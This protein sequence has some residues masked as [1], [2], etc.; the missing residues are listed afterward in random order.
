MQSPVQTPNSIIIITNSTQFRRLSRWIVPR[1]CFYARHYSRSSWHDLWHAHEQP[2]DN[3]VRGQS[4]CKMSSTVA[5]LLLQFTV[6]S[7]GSPPLASLQCDAAFRS[8]DRSTGRLQRLSFMLQLMGRNDC[9][10]LAFQAPTPVRSESPNVITTTALV[11]LR[12]F[13]GPWQVRCIYCC[14]TQ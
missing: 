12:L 2:C 5:P 7:H 9:M 3:N 13:P 6:V 8:I 11:W 14:A 10:A 1:L 4:V